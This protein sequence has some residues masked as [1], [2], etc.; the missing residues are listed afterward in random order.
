MTAQPDFQLI[1][2][3]SSLTELIKSFFYSEPDASRLG[4][5]RGVVFSL[6]DESISPEMDEAVAGL[7]R[8]ISEKGLQDLKEEYYELF[9]NP[10]SR[11]SVNMNLSY[12]R[13]GH[14]FGQALVECREFLKKA[15]IEKKEG[16][17]DTEDSLVVMLD[18][19]QEL[20]N[21][22]RKDPA[23]A[24]VLEGEFLNRFLL[25]LGAA[26]EKAMEKNPQAS[27]YR[28]CSHFL[29]AYLFMERS[30]TFGPSGIQSY[31]VESN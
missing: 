29:N 9:T 30:L 11:H 3:R 26:L 16:V 17:S 2:I 27:F 23:D 18:I 22:E 10:F 13:D 15:G 24:S 5:W 14:N 19:Y 31:S 12:Y 20:I 21:R 6:S 4:L 7:S 28:A 8:C 25:P 1:K